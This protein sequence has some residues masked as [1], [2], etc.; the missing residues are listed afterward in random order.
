M[1]YVGNDVPGKFLPDPFREGERVYRSGDL[2]KWLADG[3]LSFFGRTDDQV[4]LRGFR[5]QLSEI[6]VRLA[7]H[8]GITMS[9]VLLREQAE[10]KHLVGYYTGSDELMPATLKLFLSQTLPGYMVP[11][12]FVRLENMP[13]TPTGK[14]DK[15]ALPDP[16]PEYKEAYVAPTNEVEAQLVKIWSAVLG[17]DKISIYSNYFD[18]GGHSLSII[19][20]NKMINDH[21]KCNI[22]I[23]SIFRLPNIQALADFIINGDTKIKQ[24]EEGLDEREDALGLISELIN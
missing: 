1:G 2:A 16:V 4:K 23:A 19:K 18:L 11:S 24:L 20:M 13:L 6:E 7:A 21:F 12:Y 8:T 17:V 3:N 10:E 14:I 5:I 9:A 22:S 15:K